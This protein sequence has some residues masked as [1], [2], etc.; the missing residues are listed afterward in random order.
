M[1]K[2]IFVVIEQRDSV[3]QNVGY[4]L[5]GEAESL[6]YD[7]KQRVVAVFLGSGIAHKA[8]DLIYYGADEVLV[9]DDP[10]LGEYMTEPYAKALYEIIR[11]NDPEIVLFGATSIGRDLAPRLSAR[12]KTG[13]TADCTALCIDPETKLLRMTRPAFGG[14]L[15]AVIV[16]KNHRPQMATV[17]PGVMQPLERDESRKGSVK[18][19]NVAFTP[20]DKNIEILEVIPKREICGDICKAK[21]LVSGGRGVGGTEGFRSL[22]DLADM[23]GGEVSGSRAAIES[24]WIDKERQVG[25]TGKTVRPDVYIACGISGAIQH[26][27][28]MENSGLIIAI[29]KNETAPIFGVAD[30][31][32][33]GDLNAILPKLTEA[34][35]IAK[36]EGAAY[37]APTKKYLGME[38]VLFHT[39]R[40]IAYLTVN[41]PKSLNALNEK[42]LQEIGAIADKLKDDDSVKVLIVRGAGGRAFAA[43][44]DIAAMQNMDEQAGRAISQLAQ[45]VFCK[46]KDLPQIVIAA[47]NGYALGGGQRACHGV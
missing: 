12:L 18:I 44:A 3:I 9:V 28:G 43:G 7:L 40:G 39:D 27:A 19:V 14:N 31:G 25:Q 42:T 23:L 32:I 26:V 45:S 15:M 24:G 21:Y 4:E 5:L 13:L 46:I 2:D 33:V 10:I 20:S 11:E 30:L 47:I 34:V 16:C 6:A 41:R 22:K 8:N 35:K 1:S 38:N 37:V 29:N 17:R 36:A